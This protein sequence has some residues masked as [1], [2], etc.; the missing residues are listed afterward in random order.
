MAVSRFPLLK[1]RHGFVDNSPDDTAGRLR[2]GLPGVLFGHLPTE[3]YRPATERLR[4]RDWLGG[5]DSL[6]EVLEAKWRA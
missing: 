6:L 2:I 5:R 3:G 4:C 1:V